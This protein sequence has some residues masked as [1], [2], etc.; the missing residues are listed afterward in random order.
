MRC[1]W[2]MLFS[3][4]VLNM[5][6]A[7]QVP[8]FGGPLQDESKPDT[9]RRLPYRDTFTAIHIELPADVLYDFDQAEVRS[10]AADLM[11]QAANLIFEHAEGPVHIECHSDR[12]PPAIGQKLAERCAAAVTQWLITKENLAKVKFT[13][14][15]TSVPPPGT[16]NPNDPFAPKPRRRANITIDFAKK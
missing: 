9:Y 13:T 12:T 1:A 15:G 3:C 16:P 11:Q 6:A 8:L 7:A 10:N 4:V 2:L 5:P 14:L